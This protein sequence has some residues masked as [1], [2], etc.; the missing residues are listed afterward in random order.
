MEYGKIECVINGHRF[1]P[2]EDADMEFEWPPL[3][4]R[5]KDEEAARWN[6]FPE[7]AIGD[8]VDIQRKA[9]LRNIWRYDD[10]LKLLFIHADGSLWEQ[11]L[12]FK[13]EVADERAAEMMRFKEK[14][15]DVHIKGIFLGMN[16]SGA[17][18]VG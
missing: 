8:E 6:P 11:E 9:T 14:E 10:T 13:P 15:V 5:E 4:Q 12:H 7:Y 18:L 16:S 17:F 3:E 2:I 1:E